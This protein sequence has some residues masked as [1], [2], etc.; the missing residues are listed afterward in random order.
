VSHGDANAGTTRSRVG[1]ALKS[2]ALELRRTPVLLA[3]LVVAPAY[4]ISV[5]TTV[6]P[7]G[8]AR[9]H[10]AGETVRTTLPKAFPA[11][12]TPMTAALLA[13]IAGL[14]LMGTAADADARLVVAGFRAREVV[15]ARLGLLVG[16]AAVATA[17]SGGVMLTAFTPESVGW[18]FLGVGLTALVYGM[19]GVLAGVVLD[20]LAGVYVILFGSMIDLFI[21]QNPLAT[22]APA[23]ATYLPGHFPLVL[24][25]D[26]GFTGGVDL[27]TLGWALAYL[28]VL[29]VA[30][31]TAFALELRLD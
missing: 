15:L 21:F 18:F 27:V 20:R 23:A 25:M 29:T 24:A 28:A 14:F 7:D 4:V 10:V 16:I 22:D 13:G 19:V 12:T 6:A 3:L 5:F 2:G 26:A 9:V 8:P 11:F 31:T 17:V 30:A 1:A